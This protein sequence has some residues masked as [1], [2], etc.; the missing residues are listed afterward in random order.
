MAL[1]VEELQSTKSP[2]LSRKAGN[3]ISVLALLL[4]L[5]SQAVWSSAFPRSRSAGIH[6]LGQV[7][8]RLGHHWAFML[9]SEQY[10]RNAYVMCFL[11]R[12][13]WLLLHDVG[14]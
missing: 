13:H 10:R 12:G 14:S 6:P 8:G 5:E 1:R 11:T 9:P 2:G 7:S 4:L 3:S